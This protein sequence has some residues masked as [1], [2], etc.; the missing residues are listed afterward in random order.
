MNEIHQIQTDQA[1]EIKF[2]RKLLR[3]FQKETG[4]TYEAFKE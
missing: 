1:K 3:D 2:E 4:E